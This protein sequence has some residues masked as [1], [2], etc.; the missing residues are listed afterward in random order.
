MSLFHVGQMDGKL[1]FIN[2][3]NIFMSQISNYIYSKNA[4]LVTNKEVKVHIRK[5]TMKYM[6]YY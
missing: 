2:V 3:E 5:S 4:S 6:V 1:H